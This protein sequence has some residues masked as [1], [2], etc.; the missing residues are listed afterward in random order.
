MKYL[1]SKEVLII[2]ALIIDETGGSHGIRDVELLKSIVHKPKTMFGGRELY[3]D[4]F[5]KAA[6]LLEALANYHVF[7]DGN[8]RT[9]LAAT[10]RFLFLNGYE[11]AASNRDAETL[12]I[13][14]ATK[15]KGVEN[16]KNWLR[17]NSNPL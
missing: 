11:L 7:I 5:S 1:S 2:H 13:K 14:V 12:M 4:I 16:I 6:V 3:K 15:E 9:A 17:K 10:S 8:K